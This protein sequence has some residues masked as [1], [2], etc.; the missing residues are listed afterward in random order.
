MTVRT[1]IVPAAIVLCHVPLP[2]GLG[3][4][5]QATLVAHKGLDA[6]VRSHVSIQQTLP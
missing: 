2:V 6:S 3:A 4:K 5:L 1:L